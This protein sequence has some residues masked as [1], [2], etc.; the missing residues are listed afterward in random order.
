MPP[1][2]YMP[3]FA[4]SALK[5]LTQTLDQLSNVIEIGDWLILT[6]VSADPY[7]F[8]SLFVF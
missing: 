7:D 3:K 6:E 2:G 1:S 5:A 4:S 8:H